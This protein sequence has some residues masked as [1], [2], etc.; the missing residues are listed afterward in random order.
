MLIAVLALQFVA[1]LAIAALF[2]R[3]TPPAQPDPALVGLPDQLARLVGEEARRTR[4]DN[5]A[6]ATRLRNEVVGSIST[7]GE[8]LKFDL[9]SFREDN[10]AAA[11]KLRLDVEQKMHAISQDFAS[12]RNETTLKHASL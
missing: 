2:L 9:R 1:L 10:T 8:G 3:K 7:L 4:E 5:A 12:F 6:A 11:D